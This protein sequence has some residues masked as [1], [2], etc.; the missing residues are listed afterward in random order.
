MTEA[1]A[2]LNDVSN[3][4]TFMSNNLKPATTF[5]QQV[6]ILS[7]RNISIADSKACEDF[8]SKVNYYRLSGYLLPFKRTPSDVN[9]I[10]PVSFKTIVNIYRFDAEMRN[11]LSYAIEKIEIY[12]RT[13]LA[14]FHGIKYGPAGYMDIK[15]FNGRHDHIRFITHI[16]KCIKDNSKSPVVIHHKNAY[17]GN[18]P[19]WVII[20]FFTCGMLSYFYTDLKNP[21]KTNLSMSLYNI[22]YQTLSS[23]MRCLT[24][25][26]NRCAH[27]SRLYYWN[28][29]AV[30]RMPKGNKFTA[31]NQLFSQIYMLKLMYPDKNKWNNDVHKPLVR[32]FN[33]YKDSISKEHIGFP[34][35]WKS[36]L[37][38]K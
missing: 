23:W 29:L 35:R 38:Y 20:D 26:R 34:Y 17:A 36:M 32:L 15:N 8:L 4:G 5:E 2:P 19:I 12:M 37:K 9:C 22:N 30:P 18:F 21:D 11:I 3:G 7:S 27:Y 24:D 14:Y 25:L 33:K 28:F 13:Q 6:K 10:I 16:N 1:P 31:N